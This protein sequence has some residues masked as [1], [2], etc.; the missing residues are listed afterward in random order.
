MHPQYIFQRLLNLEINA[1]GAAGHFHRDK[2]RGMV[3]DRFYWPSLQQ[4]V[5]HIVS[6]CRTCQTA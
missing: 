3:E 5:A 1:G 4:D 6:Q 2:T